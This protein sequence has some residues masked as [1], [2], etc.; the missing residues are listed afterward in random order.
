[1]SGDLNWNSVVLALHFDGA[2]G[3]TT[4][5]DQ[6]G[7]TVTPSG[8][9]SIS[10]AQSK[11]GGAS[12]YFDGTGDYLSIAANSGF[13]FGT[14]DFTIEA[15][16]RPASI[17]AGYG[18][19]VTT[20][21]T[22]SFGIYRKG[23]AFVFYYGADRITSGA[24]SADTWYHI[25]LD[26]TGNTVT[27]YLDGQSVGTYILSDSLSSINPLRI[28]TNTGATGDF[29][30]GYIDDVRITKGVARHTAN[31]TPPTEAFPDFM[32][33]S[34][35]AVAPLSVLVAPSGSASAPL[36]VTVYSYGESTAPITIRVGPLGL[37]ASPV[38]VLIAPFGAAQAPIGV[39]VFGRGDAVAPIR[40]SVFQYGEAGTGLAVTVAPVAL[41]TGAETVADAGPAAAVWI[42]Q[43]SIAGED[44]TDMVVGEITI[45]AEEGAARIADFVLM[46]ESGEPINLAAWTGKPV[47][48]SIA[49]IST[50]APRYA[51]PLFN[52]VVNLPSVNLVEGTIAIRCTDDLQGRLDNM[53]RG[54]IDAAVVGYW[55]PAVFDQASAGWKYAQDKLSTVSASLDISADG[56]LRLTP[57]AAKSSADLTIDEDFVIDGSLS[58]DVAERSSLVNR[59]SID[60]AYRFPR[61]K[62]EAHAVTYSYSHETH[63]LEERWYLQREAVLNALQSAGGDIDNISWEPLPDTQQT[64][65]GVIFIPNPAIDPYLCLGFSATVGFH[66]SQQV[67]ENYRIIVQNWKSVSAVGARPESMTGALEGKYPDAESVETAVALY[68]SGI[69]GIPPVDTAPLVSGHTNAKTP[70]LTS[71]T[72]RSTAE[73]AIET[74]VAIAKAR[75][76]GSHRN[77]RVS[78]AVPLN[79]AIDLDK[80]IAITAGGVSAKGKCRRLVHRMSPESGEA[81]TE[82]DVAICSVIGVGISHDDTPAVAPDA[83]VWVPTPLP[84]APTI[85]FNSGKTEDH[86]F[87]ITF[88]GVEDAERDTAAFPIESTYAASLVEDEFT[89]TL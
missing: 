66:Y 57:W 12:G 30:S 15:F 9:A 19:I 76:W 71:D 59:I 6:K 51:I 63:I 41:V 46:P 20:L 8:N 35:V 81:T 47:S 55:S 31:F 1:M 21:T 48:I 44:V 75:I 62:S 69:A 11:F 86:T 4:F 22:Q 54:E 38:S 23:A 89:I 80:T 50:G 37:A 60:F 78:V 53:T 43:V 24:I 68:K 64:I 88:P 16:V 65:G 5:T 36:G 25:E 40:V 10:T 67:E 49:D 17:A 84:G 27:L 73:A 39:T 83:P 74:L 2:N 52:G 77:S 70:T 18:G 45:E 56:A 3:S 14:G 87:S 26:R 32:Y 42:A 79:P 33:P 7:N 29:F 13:A 28:G 34:G 82:V 58:V 85:A 61:L 72:D